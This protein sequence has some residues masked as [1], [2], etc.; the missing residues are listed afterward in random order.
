ML[1]SEDT[2]LRSLF[3]ARLK[4]L[5]AEKGWN[6]TK[7]AARVG[8]SLSYYC[9]LERGAKEP[10]FS[11]LAN[12]ARAFGVDEFDLFCFPGSTERHDI[13]DDLRRAPEAVR[14]TIQSVLRDELAR[15]FAGA[16]GPNERIAKLPARAAR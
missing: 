10:T 11:M 3:G 12:I 14:L 8:C 16:D 5:R 6:A 1:N 13:C 15:H 7:T 2:G 4:A 9:K